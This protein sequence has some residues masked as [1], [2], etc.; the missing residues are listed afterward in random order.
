MLV[1]LS[2]AL[3]CAAASGQQTFGPVRN[4]PGAPAS[5][6]FAQYAGLIVVNRTC[7]ASVFAWLAKSAAGDTSTTD[8]VLFL[9]G[10]PGS[11]SFLAWFFENV[12][13]FTI[14]GNG[15]SLQMNPFAWNRQ[16]DLLMMDQPAGVGLAYTSN[17]CLPINTDQSSAQLAGAIEWMFKNKELKLAGKRLW[18]FGESYAGTWV[19]L[20]AQKLLSLTVVKLGG[21]G[22]GDGWTNPLIQQQT[23]AD[24]AYGNVHLCCLFFAPSDLT[25]FFLFQPTD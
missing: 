16:V 1:L 6:P 17:T 12:G 3:F 23:Y 5:V 13:P 9:N 7:P 10:G 4:L 19:P 11:S 15:T 24:Y 14:V 2:I 25:F 8:V 22:I 21:M 18:L 20:L